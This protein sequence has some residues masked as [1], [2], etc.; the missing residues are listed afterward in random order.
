MK[1]LL[2]PLLL[3]LMVGSAYGGVYKWVDSK[4]EVH[5]GDQP[6]PSNKTQKL[7]IDT[8]APSASS[9]ADTKASPAKTMNDKE[10]D[11]RKRRVEAAE[12]QK[13]QDQ[14]AI[15]SKQ[16]QENCNNARGNV[17]S[18][19]EG[20]RVV[21]FDDKGERVYLDDA[22]RQKSLENAKKAVEDWCK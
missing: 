1:K 13:K 6:P 9:A 18:L 10:V 4:G 3:S 5:Y 19:Q 2:L 16:K 12:A 21:K 11:F 7:N 17:R 22:A 20:G 8:P 15:E 14:A